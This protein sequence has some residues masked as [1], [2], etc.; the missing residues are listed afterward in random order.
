MPVKK[1]SEKEE[2]KQTNYQILKSYCSDLTFNN[3]IYVKIIRSPV[4]KGTIKEI[5]FEKIPDNYFLFTAKDFG[6]QNYVETLDIQNE[7]LAGEKVFYKGQPIALLAGPDISELE[8]L[9]K[10]VKITIT[11]ETAQRTKIF[12]MHSV[13]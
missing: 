11:K 12:L 5:S 1:K 4:S 8:V 13:L 9:S 7:I 2:N 3:M 10:E 6:E